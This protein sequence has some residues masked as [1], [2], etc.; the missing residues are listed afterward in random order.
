M[1]SLKIVHGALLLDGH[2]DQDGTFLAL[3]EI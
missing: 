1:E 3:R 2:V